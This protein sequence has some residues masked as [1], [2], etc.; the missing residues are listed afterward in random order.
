MS[1]STIRSIVDN[2]HSLGAV[3][4]ATEGLDVV[5]RVR[6]AKR[7]GHDV[8]DRQRLL[9]AT[10]QADVAVV[11]AKLLPFRSGKGTA[12]T[13]HSR[14]SLVVLFCRKSRVAFVEY[15]SKF[16]FST[17][18]F[19]QEHWICLGSLPSSLLAYTAPF[20]H[21][22]WV[23]SF[24]FSLMLFCL[25]GVIELPLAR[26]LRKSFGVLVMPFE[27]TYLASGAYAPGEFGILMEVGT[28]FPLLALSTIGDILSFV[29]WRY[30]L[31]FTHALRVLCVNKMF[32]GNSK[33][34]IKEAI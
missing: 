5:N 4:C 11:V 8:I 23:I 17:A 3:A 21:L 10:T 26:L 24:P 6:A 9:F 34:S 28:R 13:E 29:F 15:T 16:T 30:W 20:F 31:R 32:V 12:A 14:L 2:L 27:R 7:D 25:F 33:Y 18:F 22:L 19:L 1:S